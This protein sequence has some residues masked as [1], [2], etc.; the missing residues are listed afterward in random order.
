MADHHDAHEHGTMDTTVQEQTYEGFI[1]FGVR[2][3]IACIAV[4]VFLAI[5]RT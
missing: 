1:K 5:F 2:L 4:L 3:S